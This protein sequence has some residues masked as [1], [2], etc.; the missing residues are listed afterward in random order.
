MLDHYLI[1]YYYPMGILIN[2]Y[3]KRIHLISI[4]FK[5]YFIIGYYF[6]FVPYIYMNLIR[7]NLFRK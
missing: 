6:Y 1:N 7:E 4:C 3:F 5:I 2:L